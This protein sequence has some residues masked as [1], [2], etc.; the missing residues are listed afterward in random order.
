MTVHIMVELSQWQSLTLQY[1]C[2][3]H[4]MKHFPSCFLDFRSNV[5][6]LSM[7]LTQVVPFLFS[8]RTSP[9]CHST[10]LSIQS[11]SDVVDIY[12]TLPVIVDLWRRYQEV[13]IRFDYDE[14]YKKVIFLGVENHFRFPGNYGWNYVKNGANWAIQTN[15]EQ[16]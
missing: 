12:H 11:T 13:V 9:L 4:L 7:F 16:Y 6:A 2:F 3:L 14:K 15:N 8:L 1:P 5:W 10:R